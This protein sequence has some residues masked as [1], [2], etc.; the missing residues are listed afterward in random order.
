MLTRESLMRLKVLGPTFAEA[1]KAEAKFR[2]TAYRRWLLL[3]DGE[4]LFPR[5]KDDL[6]FGASLLDPTGGLPAEA[7]DDAKAAFARLKADQRE[8]ATRRRDLESWERR[9]EPPDS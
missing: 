5:P 3:V 2:R 8:A 6:A 1:L 7:T 4:G 9:L